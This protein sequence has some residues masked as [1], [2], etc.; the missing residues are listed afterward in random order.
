MYNL[1]GWYMNERYLFTVLHKTE[2]E[3]N[4]GKK[5]VYDIKQGSENMP[6]G[7]SPVHHLFLWIKFYWHTATLIHLHIVYGWLHPIMAELI[8]FDKDHMANKT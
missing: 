7:P 2:E 1:C 3:G 8:G 6:Y 5:Q 4:I